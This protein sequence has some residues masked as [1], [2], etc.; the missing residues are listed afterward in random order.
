MKFIES[1]I[2]ALRSLF[3]NKLR[4]SLTMLGLIIG[5]GAVI[6]L[7]SLGSGLQNYITST[8][9]GLGTNTIYVQPSNPDAPGAAEFSPVYAIPSLTLDDA[10]AIADPR[11]LI[12]AAV[13][14]PE[15]MQAT[16]VIF[17]NANINTQVAG[18][19]R[20]Y[21]DAFALE[22]GQGRFIEEK[23]VNGR[24]NVHELDVSDLV[25]LDR[26]VASYT[27]IEHA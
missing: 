23:D 2:I 24:S 26:E 8:F 22:V 1:F 27:D 15:Y 3:A 9:E 12:G 21:P 13:V 11:N 6:T 20:E 17:G 4:S 14:S 10:E 19:T 16:Q 5:V 18:V 25:T 7:M